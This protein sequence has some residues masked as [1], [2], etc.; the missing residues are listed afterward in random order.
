M[1]KNTFFFTIKIFPQ[2][3]KSLIKSKAT[4]ID[5]IP[6]KILKDSYQVI[7]PFLSEILNCSISTDV[8]PDDLKIGKVSLI[9]KSSDRDNLNNYRPISVLPTVARVFERLMY[10]QTH[11]YFTENKLLQQQQSGF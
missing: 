11:I 6:N 10:N 2:S 4:G 7:A 1:V 8:F 3:K 9:E 5:N